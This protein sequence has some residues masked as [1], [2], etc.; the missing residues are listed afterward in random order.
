LFWE[1]FHLNTRL[2][3]FLAENNVTHESQI[4]FS[5][6]SRTSDHLFVLKCLV[7]KYINSGGKKLFVCFVDFRKE[8][9]TV[10]HPGIRL[11]LLR[12]NLNG[13]FYRILCIMYGNNYM[14]MSVKLGNKL[15][16]PFKSQLVVKQGDVLSPNIFKIF[17]NDFGTLIDKSEIGAKLSNKTIG[18]LLY[19]DDLGLISDSKQ[20]LQKQLDI[21]DTYS[22]HK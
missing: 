15:T 13:Y 10:I 18:C 1:N 22:K 17:L 16:D 11:K 3:K 20:G 4:G 6:K 19:A 21:F 5:K 8:F 7:D 2:D 9:D 12:N 14:Y